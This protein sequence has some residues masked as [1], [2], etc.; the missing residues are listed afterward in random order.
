MSF[1]VFKAR[2]TAIAAAAGCKVTSCE[3]DESTGCHFARCGDVTFRGNTESLKVQV[4]W[5][6]GHVAHSDLEGV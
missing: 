4:R 6:S 5:G 3:H 2:I 1:E